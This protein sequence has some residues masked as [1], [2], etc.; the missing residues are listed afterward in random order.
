MPTRCC[1]TASRW[2]P[3]SLGSGTCTRVPGAAGE[4]AEVWRRVLG[5]R[6]W[7]LSRE[8]AV[9]TGWFG[10]VDEEYV[11]RIGDVVAVA[12]GSTVLSSPRTDSIVSSLV[13]QH[14]GMTDDELAVPL[15]RVEG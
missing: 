10:A 14:G 11:A 3:A 8:Q 9:G 5:E 4:V 2:S 12:R 6:A 13:G 15:R 7:V 1:G